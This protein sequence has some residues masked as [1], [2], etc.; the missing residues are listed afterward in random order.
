MRTLQRNNE[1]R[2]ILNLAASIHPEVIM[3]IGVDH[4]GTFVRWAGI[5]DAKG[6]V[7]GIDRNPQTPEI[8]NSRFANRTP[9]FCKI[10]VGDTK[11]P[12]TLEAAKAVLGARK[13]DFL[14]IDGDHSY[15]AVKSDYEIF[16]PL[17]R[18]EG[19]I[20]FHDIAVPPTVVDPYDRSKFCGVMRFWNELKN[21][22]KKEFVDR[23][24]RPPYGIGVI[25]NDAG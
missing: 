16:S 14:F 17:V 5:V 15:E 11:D 1:L 8:V 13:V 19:I 23:T 4:G 7:I 22:T 9:A 24:A 20:S 6:L 2:E 3:E 10:I 25:V 18:A 21:K 12:K